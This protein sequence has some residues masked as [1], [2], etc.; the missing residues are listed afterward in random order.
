MRID[1]DAP[2]SSSDATYVVSVGHDDQGIFFSCSCPAGVFWKLCKHKLKVL[3]AA[4]GNAAS[5]PDAK[6]HDIRRLIEGTD[7]PQLLNRVNQA[8]LELQSVKRALE[9]AKKGLEKSLNGRRSRK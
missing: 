7:I 1:I 5:Y 6:Y 4:S 3:N 8:D 2:S 9:S